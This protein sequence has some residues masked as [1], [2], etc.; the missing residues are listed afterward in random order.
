MGDP[1]SVA[2]SIAGLISIGDAVFMK[3]YHYV[4]TVRKAEQEVFDLKRE[5]VALTGVL[6]NIHLIVEDLED[7]KSFHNC[8][9]I[10]HVNAC[11]NILHNLEKTLGKMQFSKD[12][13]TRTI[14]LR[15]SWPFKTAET[16]TLCEELRAHRGTL[17]LA[18]SADSMV[19]LLQF[20]SSQK[21]IVAQLENVQKAIRDN[22]ELETRVKLDEDRRRVLNYFLTSWLNGSGSGIWLSG[23]PGAGKTVLSALIIQKC[24]DSRIPGRAV[25]YYYCDYKNVQT[26][27][28]AN[29]FGALAAQI[30][31]QDESCLILLEQ[32]YEA[33]HPRSQMER[34][35]S[36]EE[37]VKLLHQMS[38][39]F[40]DV[41]IVLDGL[42]ECG[43][44][45]A[46]ASDL[47]FNLFQAPQKNLSLALLSRN[48][49][50][51]RNVFDDPSCKHIE[52][53]AHTEDVEHYVRTEVEKR[54]R[55]KLL[56]N[57]NP[58]LKNL[59]IKRL[60]SKAQGMFRWVSCQLDH[61]CKCET[62]AQLRKALNQLPKTLHETYERILLR[63]KDQSIPL[64]IKTL[65]WLAYSWIPLRIE[66]L[67]D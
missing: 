51:I 66:E 4:K 2:G 10:D 46:T 35:P 19:A 49:V 40:D 63:I 25:A 11:L 55:K 17:Q 20:L 7:D 22:Q 47:L 39:R 61:L 37:L 44:N 1:L 9:R 27:Q 29:N 6:H 38:S 36:A 15:L 23:I 12:Q 48:E 65:R 8:I 52:V 32:Y 21:H 60:V 31:I 3:I 59:M 53:A 28:V 34:H 42:D 18:L 14:I 26:Q 56:L 50:E 41:R 24:L 58:E 30:A 33:L 45:T 43:D 5:L 67:L 62:N 13:K 64:V 57:C 54:T 16:K